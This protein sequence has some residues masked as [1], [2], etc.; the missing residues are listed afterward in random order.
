MRIFLI[1]LAAGL[2]LPA[3]HD[4]SQMDMSGML[5]MQHMSAAP[6][7]QAS[8]T[9]FN[10]AASP[11]NMIH[12]HAGSWQLMLHG[13]AF[14]T[15]IRQTGPRGADKF[16]SMN[17]F[18]G[19]ATHTLGGG[20]FAVR[21]MLSLDPA[22]ITDRRYP[23]LFQTGET[24]YGKPIVDG[25]HPHNLFME[26]ALEYR[27]PLADKW[28]MWLYAAPVGDPALGPVAY[29]HRVSAAELPQATLGHHLE[30]STHIS[31][32]VVT[33]GVGR[34]IFGLEASGFHGAE[35]NE[36]RWTIEQ[37]AIDSYSARFTVTP[38]ARWSGQISAGRLTRPEA[39]EPGDQIRT[40]ASA[41]YVRPYA[42]GDWATS[43]IWGRVH[44]TDNQANLNG[45]DIESVARFR[46]RNYVTGRIELVDKDELFAAGNP[47]CGQSFRIGAYTAGYTRDFDLVPKI[48]AGLGANFTTYSMPGAVHQYYGGHPVAAMIFLRLRLRVQN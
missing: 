42:Q 44:K 40:E 8:G 43:L 46:R 15:D 37:G 28:N 7:M 31:D 47:L 35:P 22:T 12:L 4:M 20:T 26:L 17:W 33:A 38:N 48:S 34:G 2:P 25:Q 14:V 9:G 3:Q 41:T 16:V 23:E 6:P 45:Y 29:P 1:L 19:E 21:S 32:D 10:P 11:M 30:D 5:G 13:V 36:N 24:A 27:R 18:M 39:L